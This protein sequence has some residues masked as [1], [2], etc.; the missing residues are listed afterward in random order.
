MDAQG[1]EA[2]ITEVCWARGLLYPLRGAPT[3]D[4][5]PSLAIDMVGAPTESGISQK[6]SSYMKHGPKSYPC[7]SLQRQFQGRLVGWN[8]WKKERQAYNS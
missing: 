3:G 6:T 5:K 8:P 1:P 7:K 2:A 4:E